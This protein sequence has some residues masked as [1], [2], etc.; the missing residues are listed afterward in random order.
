MMDSGSPRTSTRT[1]STPSCTS[2]CHSCSSEAYSMK[3]TQATLCVIIWASNTN[4]SW[5]KHLPHPNIRHAKA[6]HNES[7]DPSA[8]KIHLVA[9]GSLLSQ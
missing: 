5:V 1:A 9:L 3:T 2:S 4:K 8:T 7:S 6:V